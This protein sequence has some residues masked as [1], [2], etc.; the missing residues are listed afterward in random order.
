VELRRKL[1]RRASQEI[2][3]VGRRTLTLLALRFSNAQPAASNENLRE[4]LALSQDRGTMRECCCRS[5]PNLHLLFFRWL[6]GYAFLFGMETNL[7]RAKGF[8][9]LCRQRRCWSRASAFARGCSWRPRKTFR[10]T[11]G[12]ECPSSADFNAGD[13]PH[14]ESRCWKC[15]N[16]FY[17]AGSWA[18]SNCV[19]LFFTEPTRGA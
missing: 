3:R 16:K 6:S 12:G 13:E 7:E 10:R 4:A 17:R 1:V 18:P 9:A 8:V 2:L 15:R 5:K 11:R 14:L 19:A